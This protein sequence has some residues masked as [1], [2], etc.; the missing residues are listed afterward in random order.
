MDDFNIKL[1]F[2]EIRHKWNYELHFICIVCAIGTND[3]DA[4]IPS[5]F[6]NERTEIQIRRG[7]LKIDLL[8]RYV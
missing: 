6:D 2:L 3:T 7:K 8:H 1:Y 5:S 4:N